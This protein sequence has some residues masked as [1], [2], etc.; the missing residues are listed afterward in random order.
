MIVKINDSN[1]PM[2]LNAW[3]VTFP[4]D[5]PNETRLCYT[6]GVGAAQS[7]M[8]TLPVNQKTFL[9]FLDDH[10]DDQIIDLTELQ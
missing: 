8:I 1:W 9:T 2:L 7:Y 6:W 10:E 5:A 3:N 4:P